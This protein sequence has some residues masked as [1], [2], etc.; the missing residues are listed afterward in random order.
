MAYS[1]TY[2]MLLSVTAEIM[3]ISILHT[4]NDNLSWELLPA[5]LVK[6]LKILGQ[7]SFTILNASMHYCVCCN[8]ASDPLYHDMAIIH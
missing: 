2:C 5:F 8:F 1:A 6:M 4:I 7:K 3:F